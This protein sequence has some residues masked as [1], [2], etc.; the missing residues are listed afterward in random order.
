MV[1]TKIDLRDDGKTI[2]HQKGMDSVTY[3]D[4]ERVAKEIGAVG[5]YECSALSRVGLDSLFEEAIRFGSCV[6]VNVVPL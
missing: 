5:Y 1:G 6:D 3:E 2:I 4:G